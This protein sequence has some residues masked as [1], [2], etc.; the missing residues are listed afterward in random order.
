MDGA[1]VLPLPHQ[2]SRARAPR[3]QVPDNRLEGD[4]GKLK[5]L[6][7][8]T[9][10]FQSMRTA[11]ATI[12]GFEVMWMF[13]KEGQFRFWIE[14]VGATTEVSFINHLLGS[15]PEPMAARPNHHAF[16]AILCNG[17]ASRSAS[18]PAL[19]LQRRAASPSAVSPGSDR[20]PIGSLPRSVG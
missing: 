11:W 7:R 16:N 10:G 15:M 19:P 2:L 8:S 1:L 13:K 17:C 20:N 4:H 14:A 12:T 18:A 3:S 6:I 5:R 9:L